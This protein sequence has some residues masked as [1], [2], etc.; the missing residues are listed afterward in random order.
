MLHAK[1]CQFSAA[2]NDYLHAARWDSAAGCRSFPTE[3]E[4]TVALQWKHEGAPE[5]VTCDAVKLTA[6]LKKKPTLQAFLAVLRRKLETD[7][8]ERRAKQGTLNL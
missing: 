5:I 6:F 7:R 3:T 8:A 1:S 4:T 2:V